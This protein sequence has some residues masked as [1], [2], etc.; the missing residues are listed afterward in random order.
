MRIIVAILAVITIAIA[1]NAAA[2]QSPSADALARLRTLAGDWEG[3][4]AWSGEHG[5][6]GTMNARYYVT[7]NGSAVVEDLLDSGQPMMTSVYHLDGAD[8]RVT[9]LCAA[10]NQPRLKAQTI[11]LAHGDIAFSMVDITN[12]RAP[13]AGHV[14]RL[15]VHLIDAD[16]VTVVFTVEGG[17]KRSDETV[18][19]KR[20]KGA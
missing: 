5:R 16:H 9:H 14:I 8:L 18:V 19:L 13:D 1:N 3:S 11:D 10:G 15:V 4:F 7:G 20:V 12:L 6:T 2:E 17:G